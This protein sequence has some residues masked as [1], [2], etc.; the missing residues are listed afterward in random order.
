MFQIDSWIGSLPKNSFPELSAMS[1]TQNQDLLQE[2]GM[3]VY[4]ITNIVN[5]KKKKYVGITIK[6][7]EARWK[8]H[9]QETIAGSTYAIHNAIRKYGEENFNIE[10][11]D[12]ADSW[13]E[14]CDLEF[15]YIKAY[16]TF[17]HDG[18]GYNLT[19]GGEG[20]CGMILNESAK[21][22]LSKINTGKKH[23]EASK[24]K[25]SKALKGRLI[26]E[27][28][29]KKISES[30]KGKQVSDE[31]KAKMSNAKLGSVPW[32]KGMIDVFSE[33]TIRKMSGAKKGREL[34]EEH[35]KKIS[36]AN[37]GKSKGVISEETKKKMSA[38]AKRRFE[39]KDL[40]YKFSQINKGRKL[41]EETRKKMSES[42]KGKTCSAE[43][44]RKISDAAKDRWWNTKEEV[45][46]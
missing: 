35:K 15:H 21:K 38:S 5:D 23:S 4:L 33:E 25:R 7:V 46:N 22:K 9:L 12:Y 19:R 14:L 42:H 45:I 18:F 34:S 40:R 39:D 20:C 36:E 30:L 24:L 11:I 6:G 37:K 29:R 13:E 31:S 41:S 3:E 26:S 27:E 44:K 16:D 43:T 28:H 8:Q 2:V 32:N 17:A 1:F 10:K